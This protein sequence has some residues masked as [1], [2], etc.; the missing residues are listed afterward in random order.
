M[1]YLGAIIG[2]LT[3][4]FIFTV[5]LSLTL[6]PEV[7]GFHYLKKKLRRSGITDISDDF[8]LEAVGK[9]LNTGRI[10][11]SSKLEINSFMVEALDTTSRMTSDV[12]AATKSIPSDYDALMDS[13][14]KIAS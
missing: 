1:I 10:R 8:I 4:Y 5:V 12:Y 14:Q 3:A 6:K 13:W 2:A 11:G 9:A 7:T